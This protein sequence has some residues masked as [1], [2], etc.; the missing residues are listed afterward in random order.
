MD[1]DIDDFFQELKEEDKEMNT[2]DFES[3][4][5]QKE[6][7]SIYYY[8]IPIGIAASLAIVAGVFW[9]NKKQFSTDSNTQ[10]EIVI[11]LEQVPV[12]QTSEEQTSLYEWESN[13][14]SL[15]EDF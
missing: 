2:P 3:C 14:D 11:T 10:A 8:I 15:L 4:Y 9:K 7:R 13:S 5:P 6:K 1:K 12:K